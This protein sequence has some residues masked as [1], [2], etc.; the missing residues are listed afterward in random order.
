MHEKISR[1]VT[2]MLPV[3][4]LCIADGAWAF[5]LQPTYFASPFEAHSYICEV[6]EYC[7]RQGAQLYRAEFKDGSTARVWAMRARRLAERI[8]DVTGAD[9]EQVT[10]IRQEPPKAP[11]ND[12]F[13]EHAKGVAQSARIETLKKLAAQEPPS[14]DCSARREILAARLELGEM[15]DTSWEQ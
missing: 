1:Y 11:V 8:E 13:N 15:G 14:H 6:D 5:R 4:G 7:S 2:T 12:S 3:A 10:P 9:V